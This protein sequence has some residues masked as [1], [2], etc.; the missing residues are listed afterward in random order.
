MFGSRQ[1]D[2]CHIHRATALGGIPQLQHSLPSSPR[3]GSAARGLHRGNGVWVAPVHMF[4]NVGHHGHHLI[5]A[6]QGRQQLVTG[7]Q[8][9]LC[10]HVVG[11]RHR[12]ANVRLARYRHDVGKPL[13]HILHRHV[14]DIGERQ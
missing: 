8:L 6:Q 1:G 13:P 10:R 12:L 11:R 5:E 7:R 9:G 3:A 2:L 4:Q 14:D